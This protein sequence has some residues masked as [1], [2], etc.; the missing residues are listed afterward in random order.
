MASYLT[1]IGVRKETHTKLRKL[2]G[3]LQASLGRRVSL[4]ETVN[5]LLDFVTRCV[6]EINNE[7]ITKYNPPR[8]PVCGGPLSLH[9]ET[10]ALLCLSCGRVYR[11]CSV[12]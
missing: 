1:T 6:G 10:G 12:E 5:Y 9:S 2:A 11:L 3:V 8:C 4:D 7:V